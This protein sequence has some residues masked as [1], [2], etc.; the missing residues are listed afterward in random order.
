M[1]NNIMETNIIKNKIVNKYNTIEQYK[2]R[3]GFSGL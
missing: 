1:L 2:K 3:F